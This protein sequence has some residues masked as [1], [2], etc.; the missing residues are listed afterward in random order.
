M[1]PSPKTGRLEGAGAGARGVA[2]FGE[3][4]GPSWGTGGAGGAGIWADRNPETVCRKGHGDKF[5]SFLFEEPCNQHPN[6]MM[7]VDFVLYIDSCA[8]EVE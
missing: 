5:A 3:V 1:L 7:A 8:I 2:S 6:A 4:V